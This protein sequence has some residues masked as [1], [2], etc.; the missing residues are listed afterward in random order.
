VTST[1][2]FTANE[3]AVAT[4]SP[5]IILEVVLW[6]SLGL[7][8]WT[9]VGYPL[10]AGLVA[11]IA[12]RRVRVD[13][14]LPTVALVIAAHNEEDV[15]EARLENALLL[16]YPRDRLRIVVASD[17]SSDRTDELVRGY[18][19]RGVELS[20]APRGG[21][22]NAQNVTVR[23]LDSEI[24][25]FSDANCSWAPDALTRLVRS[26]A[27]PEV[28][29]VCGRLRLQSPEGTNQE[30]VYWRYEL[31]LRASESKLHSVTGGNGSIYAVRRERYEEVDPRFGHD[32]SF[33]YLMVK[34][35]KRAVYEPTAVASEKM[36]TDLEDEFRRKVRMFGHCWI[37]VF[38]G[39]MFGIRALGPVYWTEMISHRLL[40][41]AS[42]LLHIALLVSSIVLSL[43]RGGIY[44][45]VLGAQLLVLLAA[46]GSRLARGRIRLLA[47]PHYYLL[48]T[49]ATVIALV[50]LA[51]KGVAPVWDRPE[52]TR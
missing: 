17:A 23:G 37:L 49:A 12:P 44:W 35:G 19:E 52:G 30:G 51:T 7:L 10:V 40:R 1:R 18:A 26:F 38:K 3:P 50:E 29:Y 25:A 8:V 45:W 31:W 13:D 39:R 14:V 28:A 32:L 6:V 9:H 47:V 21:K 33:P 34:R 22:V 24:L 16:D 2:C 48:V 46:L 42:G 43:T 36:T 27:D 41:Y 5:V 11:R 4:V 15:I 20:V